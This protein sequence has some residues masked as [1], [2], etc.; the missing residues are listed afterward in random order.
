MMAERWIIEAVRTEITGHPLY[1]AAVIDLDT[2][3]IIDTDVSGAA[4]TGM[5]AVFCSAFFHLG[6]PKVVVIDQGAD[7]DAVAREAARL[8]AEVRRA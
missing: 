8:G 5:V 6:V 2:R 3:E 4:D 7:G 1:V